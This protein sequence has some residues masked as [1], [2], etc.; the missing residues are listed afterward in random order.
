M[1]LVSGGPLYRELLLDAESGEI[2]VRQ[3][4]LDEGRICIVAA[5]DTSSTEPLTLAYSTTNESMLALDILARDDN[6]EVLKSSA[7][8]RDLPPP[9]LLSETSHQKPNEFEI[10]QAAIPVASQSTLCPTTLSWANQIVAIR[11]IIFASFR[12]RLDSAKCKTSKVPESNTSTKTWTSSVTTPSIL[13]RRQRCPR[14]MRHIA[15]LRSTR[16]PVKFLLQCVESVQFGGE[17]RASTKLADNAQGVYVVTL[18][19]VDSSTGEVVGTQAR[20]V[21]PFFSCF[22]KLQIEDPRASTLQPPRI[23]LRSTRLC[24]KRH[25]RRVL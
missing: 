22:H 8:I 6:A 19:V 16:A 15:S 18:Q 9:I 24:G 20:L 2:T 1:K 4:P 25:Y 3:T 10:I 14:A 12:E 7:L 5:K 17:L 13:S 23:R 11:S 21:R